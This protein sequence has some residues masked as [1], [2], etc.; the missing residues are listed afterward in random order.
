MTSNEIYNGGE[1]KWRL[2]Q[3][4]LPFTVPSQL[5]GVHGRDENGILF[6]FDIILIFFILF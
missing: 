5:G 6:L 2:I 3:P 1:K 4:S